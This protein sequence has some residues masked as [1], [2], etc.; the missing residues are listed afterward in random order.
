MHRA[1]LLN[2]LLKWIYVYAMYFIFQK[3]VGFRFV[4]CYFVVVDF[5]FVS[6]LLLL[7]LFF[8]SYSVFVSFGLFFCFFFFWGGGVI[9]YLVGYDR[10][11][12]NQ[13]S[14]YAFKFR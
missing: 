5:F 9:T 14:T 11:P 3:C 1:I 4:Y 12:H 13:D 7:L 10:R 8:V 2:E 6:V